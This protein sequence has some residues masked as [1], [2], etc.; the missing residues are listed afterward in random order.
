MAS[1]FTMGL[2]GLVSRNVAGYVKRFEICGEWKEHEPQELAKVGRVP[3][4][5]MM[6]NS[7]VRVAV[8]RMD[9]LDSFEYVDMNVGNSLVLLI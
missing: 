1:P 2:N 9:V 3:D 8:E 7:L 6:M 5:S 4:E